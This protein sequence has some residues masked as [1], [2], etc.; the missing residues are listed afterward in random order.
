MPQRY[1]IQG[2]PELASRLRRAL[3]QQD[4]SGGELELT[5]T[6]EVL[7]KDA[8]QP[9]F[10]QDPI[11]WAVSLA[12]AAVAAEFGHVGVR[13]NGPGLCVVDKIIAFNPSA[14]MAMRLRFGRTV[15]A[16]TPGLSTNVHDRADLRGIGVDTVALTSIQ[17]LQDS[18]A[19]LQGTE[20]AV[21]M[22][23]TATPAVFSE[24]DI[25]MAPGDDVFVAGNTVNQP[26]NASFFGRWFPQ[27][28]Q[29]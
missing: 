4:I 6:P 20:I 12:I 17:G 25:V 11:Y 7:V 5:F 23:P 24:L 22:G 18:D 15:A 26:L 21:S 1:K 27:A 9:P 28:I 3:D 16:L 29:S 10:I 13:F 2:A 8:S 19:A 14:A